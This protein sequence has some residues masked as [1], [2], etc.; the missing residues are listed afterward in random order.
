MGGLMERTQEFTED[1]NER[2]EVAAKVAQASESETDVA[3]NLSESAVES[4]EQ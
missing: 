2:A 1:I 4:E 3:Q